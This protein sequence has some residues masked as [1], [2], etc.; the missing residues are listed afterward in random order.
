MGV[1]IHEGGLDVH[2][3]GLNKNQP[4]GAGAPTGHLQ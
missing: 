1:R 3:G 4:A 2:M